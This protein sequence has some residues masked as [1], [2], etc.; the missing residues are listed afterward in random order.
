MGQ[1]IRLGAAAGLVLS[2]GVVSLV[3]A[4]SNGPIDR[5]DVTT[6]A[7]VSVMGTLVMQRRPG[8][9]AGPLLLAAGV[10][11]FAGNLSSISGLAGSA[12]SELTFLHRAVLLHAALSPILHPV[13]RIRAFGPASR[14]RWMAAALTTLAGYLTSMVDALVA[15]GLVV[16]SVGFAAA[17]VVM[18]SPS[19]P[20]KWTLAATAA[21]VMVWSTSAGIAH[22]WPW[23][24]N[25]D[26]LR[27]YQVA[28]VVAAVL[29]GLGRLTRIPSPVAV[30]VAEL[31]RR[32]FR[33]AFEHAG[34]FLLASGHRLEP[35]A[36]ERTALVDLGP[37]RGQVMLAFTDPTFAALASS[38][39]LV[40]SFAM[41][42]DHHRLVGQLRSQAE[43]VAQSGRRLVAAEAESV[44]EFSADLRGEVLGR[45]R[46]MAAAT[47]QLSDTSVAVT[48]RT[49]LT[50]I[51]RELA[52]LSFGVVSS[53]AQLADA[54]RSLA[55]GFD[56][57]TG[58]GVR[59][60]ADVDPAPLELDEV[61]TRTLGLVANELVVNATRHAA[62]RHIHLRLTHSGSAVELTVSD[63]G[64]GGAVL[65]PD[66][67]LQGL[68]DRLVAL[69]GRLHV[70]SSTGGGTTIVARLPLSSYVDSLS[71]L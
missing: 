24:S 34:E 57:G 47:D 6:G 28:F 4:L 61:S 33:I 68:H 2:I 55:A 62:A 58:G 31:E 19:P 22:D 44:A 5:L 1:E 23:L 3:A 41:L 36:A 11:W 15:S 35:S 48:T 63:D 42:A 10:T 69:G 32:G 64:H 21:A 49:H 7:V 59:V 43:L 16:S 51:E 20:R 45:L 27:V 67:G 25:Q 38:P 53:A 65:A 71:P 8:S 17:V 37:E 56:R 30:E 9:I 26:R 39:E 40:A 13:A 52:G 50:D 46:L 18:S 60:T 14:T 29:S 70:T 66:G 12:A 54:L